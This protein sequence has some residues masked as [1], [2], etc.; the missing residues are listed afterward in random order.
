MKW[1]IVTIKDWR[2]WQDAIDGFDLTEQSNPGWWFRGQADLKWT[3]APSLLRVIGK[4]DPDYARAHG[5]EFGSLRRFEGRAH[6][7]LQA[8]APG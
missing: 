7:F 6:L 3:L 5:I 1:R 2:D 4:L 8:E